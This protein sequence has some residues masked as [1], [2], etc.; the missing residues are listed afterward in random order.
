ML[1]LSCVAYGLMF[2]LS[3]LAL[4]T[5][6]LGHRSI[7]EAAPNI[8]LGVLLFIFFPVAIRFVFYLFP[9][10][11]LPCIVVAGGNERSK[12][13]LSW[14]WILTSSVYFFNTISTFSSGEPSLFRLCNKDMASLPA[15]KAFSIHIRQPRDKEDEQEATRE[16]SYT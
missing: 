10:N 9:P 3:F 5:E 6:Y 13:N 14:V 1:W 8:T 7:S 12:N 15:R 11:C 4:G 16:C 2:R